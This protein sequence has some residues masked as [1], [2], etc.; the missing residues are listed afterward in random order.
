MKK[1][2]DHEVIFCSIFEYSVIE[3]KI[4]LFGLNRLFYLSKLVL[5][6]SVIKNIYIDDL[7][8]WSYFHKGG[9]R[10]TQATIEDSKG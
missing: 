7:I 10:E 2:K 3:R 6:Y 1:T 9:G 4:L 8:V 5:I